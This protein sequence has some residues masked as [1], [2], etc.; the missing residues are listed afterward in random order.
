MCYKGGTTFQ[1]ALFGTG[2]RVH[3]DLFANR[4]KKERKDVGFCVNLYGG[5]YSK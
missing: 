1:S 4:G 2:E 3:V 5:I